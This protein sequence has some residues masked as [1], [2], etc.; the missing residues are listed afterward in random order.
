MADL[1]PAL[2]PTGDAARLLDVFAAIERS[3]VAATTLVAG[4]AAEAGLWRE[5]GTGARL[6]GWRR[7]EGPGSA[8]PWGRSRARRGWRL[9]GD[10]RGA[11]SG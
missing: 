10:D 11:A 3:M 2:M 7:R 8:R 9:A 1:R 6:R 5:K 4:R